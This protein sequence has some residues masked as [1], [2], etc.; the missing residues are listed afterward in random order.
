MMHLAK[1]LMPICLVFLAGCG[2]VRGGG[3]GFGSPFPKAPVVPPTGFLYTQ[4]KAPL[5]IDA[6]ELPA[7][8]RSGQSKA[9]YLFIPFIG[10]GFS[11]GD[12]SLEAAK[13]NGNLK[14]V[15]YADY[16]VFQILGIYAETKINAYGR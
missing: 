12:A 16:E 5:T 7:G 15:G 6:V 10:L 8:Q 4:I 1:C 2:A 13:T 9:S 11:W 3:L 14:S